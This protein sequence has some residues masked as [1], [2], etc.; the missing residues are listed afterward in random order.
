M[1]IGKS[2]LPIQQSMGIVDNT[3]IIKKPKPFVVPGYKFTYMNTGPLSVTRAIWVSKVYGDLIVKTKVRPETSKLVITNELAYVLQA[4][5]EK[6]PYY[7][8]LNL[9]A[10]TEVLLFPDQTLNYQV[11]TTNGDILSEM[12][13]FKEMNFKDK[14]IDLDASMSIGEEALSSMLIDTKTIKSGTESLLISNELLEIDHDYILSKLK[15]GKRCNKQELIDLLQPG[16]IL[17]PYPKDKK[18]LPLKILLI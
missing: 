4:L 8:P 17:I 18:K 5:D 10:L 7:R 12:P 2:T 3:E 11:V 13:E 6:Y 16:D 9:S 15:E 1:R 14:K